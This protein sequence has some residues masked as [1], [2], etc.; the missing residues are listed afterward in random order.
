M[1]LLC[2][3]SMSAAAG[4]GDLPPAGRSRF[5]YLVGNAPVP[6]PLPRLIARIRAQLEASDDG[7]SPI[8]IT[9]FPLG[10]SLRRSVAA[11]DFFQFPSVVVAVDVHSKAG[12]T[13]LRDQLFLGY[14]ERAETVEII[15][16]NEQAGRFE[17]QV[18]RDYRSGAQPKLYYASRR[19]CLACHQ[20][21][22]PIFPRALWDETPANPVVA[23]RLK[24]TGRDFYGIPIAGTDI[25][26]AIDAAVARANLLPIWQQI[27]RESCGDACRAQWLDA[28]LAY[29][30]SGNLP[31]SSELKFGDLETRW[32]KAWPQGLS[33]PTA[34]IPNRDP[35]ASVVE[36]PAASRAALPRTLDE[37]AQLAHIPAQLEPLTPRPPAEH[38]AAPDGSQLATGLAA[39]LNKADVQAFDRALAS[40]AKARA[41]TFTL[42]CRVTRKPNRTLF[43]CENTEA[44]F[45]G[46]LQEAGSARSIQI[47]RLQAGRA[48]T[49]LD[50]IFSGR[51]TKAGQFEFVLA[52]GAGTVRLSDGRRWSRLELN[53]S[54]AGQGSATITLTDDYAAVRSALPQLPLMTASVFDGSRA[55]AELQAALG[56]AGREIPSHQALAEKLPPAKLEIAVSRK[57]SGSAAQFLKYCGQCHDSANTVPPNFL[58]GDEATVNARLDNCA[59]RILYRLSMWQLAEHKRAKTAMPPATELPSLGFDATGWASSA[60]LADLLESAR[61]RIV[62]RG[63]KPEAVLAQPFEQLRACLPDAT[64]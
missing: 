50:L 12:A 13:P 62:K 33:I 25:S 30:M 15:S 58:H 44:R 31:E 6:Y 21:S 48:K 23:A 1:A 52:R 57:L 40:H 32:A 38:W 17:F 37:L 49:A 35:F 3:L 8:K 45:S 63:G 16:Y 19:L 9:L 53:A 59:E 2:C 20:N 27:W 55:L 29:V 36:A 54:A 5:D 64:P 51:A 28:A 24:A 14:N 47:D 26:N 22:A 60:P 10:R 7:L 39:L 4:E 34:S 43:E 41:Q 42:P 18:V 46:V 11:P 61:Q 56:M